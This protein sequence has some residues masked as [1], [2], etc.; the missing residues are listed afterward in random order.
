MTRPCWSADPLDMLVPATAP[1]W[2]QGIHSHFYAASA[3]FFTE[4]HLAA[5]VKG[6][7]AQSGGLPLQSYC[8]EQL[9]CWQELRGLAWER[10][11]SH[12]TT[13]AI[14][15][16]TALFG[17]S[18]QIALRH[19]NLGIHFQKSRRARSRLSAMFS[20]ASQF[21]HPAVAPAV[22][23]QNCARSCS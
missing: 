16:S 12:E 9:C 15:M 1:L 20:V 17:V 5:P 19:T 22:H 7:G 14:S 23:P 3:F 2:N 21:I 10:G 13:F 8:S 6:L 4:T 11:R 18:Q